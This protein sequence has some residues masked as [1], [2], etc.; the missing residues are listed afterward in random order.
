MSEQT[1]KKPISLPL[2]ILIAMVLGAALGFIIGEKASY[3][4]FIGDVFIR[5]LK[6]YIYPHLCKYN[7]RHFAG[8]GHVAPEEGRRLLLWFTGL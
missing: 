1:A 4:Q 3:I 7:Q 5:L 8:R 2:K 6:M